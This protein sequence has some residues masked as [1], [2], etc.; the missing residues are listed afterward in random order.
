MNYSN[1][2]YNYSPLNKSKCFGPQSYPPKDELDKYIRE[3]S[4]ITHPGEPNEH[5][6]PVDE[7]DRKKLERGHFLFLNTHP[8]EYHKTANNLIR[9]KDVNPYAVRHVFYSIENIEILQKM[10]I[11]D[12]HKRTN[13]EVVIPKQNEQSMKYVMQYVY[14]TYSRDLPYNIKRQINELNSIVLSE[15]MPGIISNIDQYIGYIR[16]ISNPIRPLDRPINA[17]NKGTKTL[18]SVMRRISEDE[19]NGRPFLPKI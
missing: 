10:I 6:C 9:Q 12:V 17:S 13:G 4:H 11:M 3:T 5:M 7:G 15:V 8:K 14:H 16:D 18:P 19:L 1:Y 2:K